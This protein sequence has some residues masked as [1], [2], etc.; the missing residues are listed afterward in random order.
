MPLQSAPVR[1]RAAALAASLLAAA[2][3]PRAQSVHCGTSQWMQRNQAR[4]APAA[5]TASA[6]RAAAAAAKPVRILETANFRI[7]YVLRGANRVKLVAEDAAFAALADSL[8]ASLPGTVT[9]DAADSTV[10]ARLESRDAG[11]PRY[12]TAMGEILEKARGYYVDTL[13][14]R[15]PRE[16]AALSIYYRAGVRPGKYPV[17]VADIGT[18]DATFRGQEI[19]ALTYPTGMGG[20]LMENDFLFNAAVAPDGSVDGDSISSRY[21]GRL[22]HNYAREWDLGLKVTCYHELYHSVQFAYTPNEDSF[23]LWYETSAVGMEE[24]KA[25]EVDDYLQYLPAYVRDLAERGMH[26]FPDGGLSRYGNGIFHV[27]LTRELGEDFD[28]ALWNRLAQNGNDIVAGL[29]HLYA[30]HGTTS[31]EIYARYG[32][33]LAFAGT[34]ARNPLPAFSPDLPL[35]PKLPRDTVDL[36]RPGAWTSPRAH[37]PLSIT[38]LHLLG[39]GGGKALVQPD[40]LLRIVL[41]RLGTDTSS[42]QILASGTVPLDVPGSG[43]EAVALVVNGHQTQPSDPVEVRPLLSRVDDEVYPY[44]NPHRRIGGGD[45]IFSK[46]TRPAL[47]TIYTESGAAIRVL[48]F[49]T[50]ANLWAWDLADARGRKVRS[51]VYYYRTD[52]GPLK[53]FFLK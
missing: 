43:G 37:P 18:A 12:I 3:T 30:S 38:A 47:V 17:D 9:G 53:P 24:R 11:H 44:P 31:Q 36:S 45:L 41:A 22:I 6:A 49:S 33:Q 8:Y 42:A 34:D 27:F 26:A 50:D 40:T 13:K 19:Y 21:Q 25:P 1:F 16:T 4:L 51:G 7:H 29:E 10:F 28:V 5:R 48:A 2:A 46:L 39:S 20:M 32:A 14:M 15:A 35:W 23:H 52:D